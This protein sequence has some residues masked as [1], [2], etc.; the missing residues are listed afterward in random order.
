VQNIPASKLTHVLYSFADNDDSGRV[1]LTDTYADLEIHFPGDSWSDSGKNAYGGI[2]QLQLLKA[3]NRNLKVL[4]SI[5]GWTYTNEKKHM[6]SPAS[7]VEG[8]KNFADSC[9]DMVRNYGFD[10]IDVDWE[11]PQDTQQGQNF[12][13]LLQEIRYALDQYAETLTFGDDSGNAMKPHFELSI[14]APAGADNY[15]NLPLHDMA[16]VLDFVNLMVC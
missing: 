3:A 5:G 7:S 12:S 15:K 16:A 6:D 2:K 8:R 13:K 14:A 9:V 11:Y 10:G 4:L 1:F